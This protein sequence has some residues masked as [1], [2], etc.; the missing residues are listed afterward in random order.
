MQAA[1]QLPWRDRSC[2]ADTNQQLLNDMAVDQYGYVAAIA[3]ITSPINH[4]GMIL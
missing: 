1:V 4:E 2:C 3:I